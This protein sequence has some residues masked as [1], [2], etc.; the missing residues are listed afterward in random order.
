M[1]SAPIDSTR[2]IDVPYVAHLARL[3]LTA[4]E[5]Q[6]FQ[7]QLD[8]ILRYVRELNA[9]NVEGVEALAH[10][11]PM[12]NVFRPDEPRPG[13]THDEALANAPDQRHDQFYVPR[14]LE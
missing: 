11:I 6:K 3:H 10:A 4:E 5:T 14:I 13:L 1:H 12:S 9:V 7:G 2:G 8:Q